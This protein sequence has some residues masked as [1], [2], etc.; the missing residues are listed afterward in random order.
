MVLIVAFVIDWL[1]GDPLYLLHPVRIIG[2]TISLMEKFLRSLRCSGV[3]GGGLLAIT[4]LTIIVFSYWGLR[5][6]LGLC[7]PWL[8]VAFDIFMVYSCV[9]L[10]DLLKHAK[11][12][13]EALEKDN[14]PEARK[15]VQRMVG[16]D[17][18]VLDVHGVARAAVESVAEG[19]LDGVFSPLNWYVIGAGCA[20]L[21]HVSPVPWAV[22]AMLVYRATNT[23][24]SMVGYQNE[25]YLYF[26]RVSAKLDDMLNFVPARL[27]VPVLFVASIVCGLNSRAGWKTALRD[28][29]KH[30]SPNSAHPESFAAGALCIRIGGPL[31]YHDGMD[32]KPWLGDGSQDATGKD[33]LSVCRLVMFA[34]WISMFASVVFLLILGQL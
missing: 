25:R 19:L 27:S 30:P 23:L 1:M 2:H 18:A 34:G 5:H 15:A 16:R 10:R 11:T 4:V 14:L 31:Q 22:T 7:H 28:R 32:D 26:G 8:A 33:I 9:A 29:L 21:V 20:L 12:V 24:D 17:A 6:V 3:L 13:A